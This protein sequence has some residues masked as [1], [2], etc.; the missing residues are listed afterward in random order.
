MFVLYAN[1]SKLA[2][3]QREPAVSG[4]VNVNTVQFQFSREWD[5]LT[6][7][8]VFRAGEISCS[9]S[10][11]EFGRC[12][13]PREVLQVPWTR[14]MAG[15]CGKQGEEVILPTVWA[16]L[17][18]IQAGAAEEP[19]G[20]DPCE[21]LLSKKG[22]T[23]GYTAEGELGLYAGDKLLSSVPVPGGTG[24]HQELSCRDAADQHPISA[25]TGLAGRLERAITT[26]SVLSATEILK[27]ME[28]Q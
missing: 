20:S 8:A 11:D 9:A 15:V 1:K 21:Q 2:V 4:S 12:A 25:I 23:L 14:L 24:N 26:D 28:V 6:C 10:L 19:P 5:G 22:D 3:R 13:V 17:G 7:T 16:D 18:T 27:I